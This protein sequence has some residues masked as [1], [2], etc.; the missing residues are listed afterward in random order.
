MDG[1]GHNRHAC[2]DVEVETDSMGILLD[3]FMSSVLFCGGS[4]SACVSFLNNG[5]LTYLRLWPCSGDDEASKGTFT[6]PKTTCVYVNVCL[7]VSVFKL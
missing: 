3:R 1:E 7:C 4:R 5:E 6:K 2:P